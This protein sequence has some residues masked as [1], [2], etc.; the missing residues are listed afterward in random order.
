[1]VNLACVYVSCAF[2]LPIIQ[3][4]LSSDTL[5]PD[6][7]LLAE[8]TLCILTDVMFILMLCFLVYFLLFQLYILFLLYTAPFD[9]LYLLVIAFAF[10]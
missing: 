5:C 2:L 4:D 6:S 1:M 10:K 8:Q 3:G 9:T 7:L